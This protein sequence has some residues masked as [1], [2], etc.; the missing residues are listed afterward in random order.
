M[1]PS[2]EKYF[3][4]F[5]VPALLVALALHTASGFFPLGIVIAK[6][7]APLVLGVLA[8]HA[9]DNPISFKYIAAITYPRACSLLW[10]AAVMILAWINA[11]ELPL[12]IAMTCL[13]VSS[14]IRPDHA[15][16]WFFD[17]EPFQSIGRVSYGMYMLHQLC[18]GFLRKA[19][20]LPPIALFGCGSVITYFVAQAS[21][22]WYES[23]FLRMKERFSHQG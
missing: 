17:W 9:L 14:V 23:V 11:H 19:A 20:P 8:A 22:R 6:I 7:S 2:L 1:V 13:V 10:L 21:F 3:R 16:A 12:S 18:L 15:L 5:A 4:S